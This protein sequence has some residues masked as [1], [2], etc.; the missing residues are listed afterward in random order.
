MDLFSKKGSFYTGANYWASNAGTDMWKNFDEKVIESDFKKMS[1]INMKVIRV[2]PLWPDFQPITAHTETDGKVLEYRFGEERIP[3]DEAGRSGICQKQIDN[4]AKMANIAEKFGI[5]LIVGLITGWMS[6]RLF[7]PPAL[8]KTNILTDPNAIKWQVRFVKYFVK[9]FKNSPAISSWDLGNECNSMYNVNS[10]DEAWLWAATISDA[11]RCEDSTRPIISGMH[12]LTTE[13]FW[14]IQDQGELT[15]ILTVHPYPIFTPC[16][17][18]DPIDTIRPQLH[19]TAEALLYRGIGKKPCFVEEI[20]ALG[21][22]NASEAVEADYLR[23]NLF[24]LWAHNCGALLW[25][26]AF[27]QGSLTQTPYFWNTI[28]SNYGCFREDGTAKPISY[29]FKKFAD[30]VDEF[31]VG[32]LPERIVDAVCIITN[33]QGDDAWKNAFSTFI[34]S[35]QAGIDVEFV[36]SREQKIPD[37]QL[38]IMPGIKGARSTTRSEIEDILSKVE[39]GS[40]LY[41]SADDCFI[42]WFPELTGIAVSTREK[43]KGTDKIYLGE[44]Q[45]K[46][47]LEIKGSYRYNVEKVESDV[48]AVDDDNRPVFVRMPYGKGY[49]YFL[50]YPVEKYVANEIGVFDDEICQPYWHIYS[51]LLE[52]CKCNKISIRDNPNVGLTEHPLNGLQRIIVAI[53]YSS[54]QSKVNILLEDCWQLA[55]LYTKTENCRQEQSQISLVLEKNSSAVFMVEKSNAF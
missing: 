30:F 9:Y 12:S 50:T 41:M 27:D 32:A 2:F 34:L 31:E 19:A 22:M 42:R 29:E 17:D 16:C 4:F 24:T 48:L 11:I 35:K 39:N 3:H 54:K 44:G 49:I 15:D 25:W 8:E 1:E 28:G 21:T 33:G 13:G 37:S 46:T 14:T 10:R 6:G 47:V 26:C 55:K 36:Y 7:V 43:C 23:S 20:G 18:F 51:K 52:S 40:I 5:K 38:Y 53:N 45:E